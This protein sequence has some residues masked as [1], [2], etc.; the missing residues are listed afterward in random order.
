MT[1]H[2]C[3]IQYREILTH[4]LQKK[5]IQEHFRNEIEKIKLNNVNDK[6]EIEETFIKE[7]METVEKYEKKVNDV[8]SYSTNIEDILSKSR[9]EKKSLE[10]KY[11]CVHIRK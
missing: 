7:K 10:K 8:L 11:N 9:I 6:K 4:N 5:E 1:R 2:L 3:N